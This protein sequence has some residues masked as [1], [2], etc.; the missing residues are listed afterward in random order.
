LAACAANAGCG[1]AASSSSSFDEYKQLQRTPLRALGVLYGEF[2]GRNGNRPPASEQQFKNYLKS[3][4]SRELERLGV[5]DSASLF[6]SP[7]DG[8]PMVVLYGKEIGP[9]GAP[10]L[11]WIAYEQQST[12]ASRYVVGRIGVVVVMDDEEFHE[13]FPHVR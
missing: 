12:E 2:M 4:P 10:G 6:V 7:R 5:A 3:V 11:P 1:N 13:L 9:P 8:R